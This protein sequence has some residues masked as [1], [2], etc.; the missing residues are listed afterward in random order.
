MTIDLWIRDFVWEV[1]RPL[2]ALLGL[3]IVDGFDLLLEIR[4]V[5]R[6]KR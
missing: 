6:R 1:G 4:D 5:F 2:A 3:V